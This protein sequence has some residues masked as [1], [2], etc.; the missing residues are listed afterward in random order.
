MVHTFDSSLDFSKSIAIFPTLVFCSGTNLKENCLMSRVLNRTEFKTPWK[1]CKCLCK[2]L[3]HL[4]RAGEP[5]SVSI[6]FF[7]VQK[8]KAKSLRYGF[9]F[10]GNPGRMVYMFLQSGTFYPEW[11]TCSESLWYSSVSLNLRRTDIRRLRNIYIHS[12]WNIS[13]SLYRIGHSVDLY[14]VQTRGLKLTA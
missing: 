12:E 2:P 11:I 10:V 13:H 8:E 9:A 3:P 5:S 4:H 6:H 1:G 14:Q 7:L